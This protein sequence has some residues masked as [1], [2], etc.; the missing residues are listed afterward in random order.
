MKEEKKLYIDDLRTPKTPG[1]WDIV[2][3]SGEAIDYVKEHGCP[4]YI[5]FDHD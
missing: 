2:R 1:P 4:E 3:T 5:S